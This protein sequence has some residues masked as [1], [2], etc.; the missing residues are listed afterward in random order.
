[1]L[2]SLLRS[3]KGKSRVIK[4]SA[5]SKELKRILNLL[6]ALSLQRTTSVVRC[7]GFEG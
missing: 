4:F 5:A 3:H 7:K 2:N 6:S 1:M